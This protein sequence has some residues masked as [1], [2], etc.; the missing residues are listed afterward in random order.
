MGPLAGLEPR[1]A[2][3]EVSHMHMF[4]YSGDRL[5]DLWHLWDT[6]ALLRQLG[7]PMPEM[8]VG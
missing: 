2:T 5:S 1:G 3:V 4:R 8:R 7:A 6:I